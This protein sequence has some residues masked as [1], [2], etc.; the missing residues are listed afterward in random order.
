MRG[1]ELLSYNAMHVHSKP[2]NEMLLILKQLF[3]D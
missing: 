3:Q 1:A 2:Q